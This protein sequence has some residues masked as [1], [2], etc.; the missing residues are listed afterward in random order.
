MRS[1]YAIGVLVSMP[2]AALL[3]CAHPEALEDRPD[4]GR[5]EITAVDTVI[6]TATGLIGYIVDMA[7][8]SSGTLYVSDGQ[9]DQVL[10]V[11]RESGEIRALGGPGQGPGEFKNV[12]ALRVVGEELLAL[13]P[14]NGRLQRLTLDGEYVGQAKA[15]PLVRSGAAYL[16][17]DG[18]M[19]LSSWGTDTALVRAF[20]AEARFLRKIGEP[21]VLRSMT[22]DPAKLKAEIAAGEVPHDIRNA[23]FVV[24]D[25]RGGLWVALQTEAEVRR[26][27][28]EGALIWSVSIDEPELA[29][30]RQEFFD[31][32]A[33]LESPFQFV[34]LSYFTDGQAVGD[35]LWLLLQTEP[36]APGVVLVIGPE[37][38]TVRR[39][40]VAG[41]GGAYKFLF[42]GRHGELWLATR[43][44][45]QLLRAT[46]ER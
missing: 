36:G 1:S 14:G 24:G 23:N 41:A 33:A 13:D 26:Y 10:R 39:I 11:S 32:N 31:R 9:A 29:Q 5:L 21:V 22:L 43:D 4:T 34:L 38:R 18:G 20:D 25:D 30:A 40:E 46:L 6:S 3:A 42:D 15:N 37:G 7:V 17:A 12:G 27:D 16:Q 28:E 8:D 44:D 35:T 2:A 19:L 45:A